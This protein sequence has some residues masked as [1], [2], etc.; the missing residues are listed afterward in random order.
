MQLVRGDTTVSEAGAMLSDQDRDRTVTLGD[1]TTAEM[2]SPA[3]RGVARFIDSLIQ[4]ALG[5][6]ALLLVFLATFCIWCATHETNG[7]QVALG[8]LTPI[9]W[10]LYAP[11]LVAARGQTLGKFTARI[12]VVCLADGAAPSF[13]R[14]IVRWAVP[15][16]IGL[17]TTMAGAPVLGQSESAIARLVPML[18]WSPLHLAS[19]MDGR[20]RGWHDK[21]ARTIVI[22]KPTADQQT[23]LHVRVH[24][25]RGLSHR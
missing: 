10:A 13:G 17:A 4:I 6:V 8:I 25:C 3:A 16:T 2:A 11:V 21:T 19:F 20:C 14:S 24:G 22:A 23:C 9:A 18:L 12:K 5:I 7:G 15:T 1:G